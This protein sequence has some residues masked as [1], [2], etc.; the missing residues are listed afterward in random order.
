M[1]Y[2]LIAGEASGDLHASCLMCELRRRDARAEFRCIGGDLMRE[3]GGTLLRHYSR[4]AYMGVVPVLMHLPTI[5]RAMK[6]CLGD[7]L[8]WH[9]D[10]LILVDY[11]GFN[12]EIAQRVKEKSADI[13]VFYYIAPKLWAWKEYRIKY[14]RRYVDS[15]FSILPF[16]V[17]FFEEKHHCP[18]NYVGNPTLDEVSAYL[19]ANPT[20]PE[21]FRHGNGLDGSPVIAL[22]AGSR[23]QEIAD[24]LPRM[25][26]A[27]L[28]LAG[29]YQLVVAGAPGIERDFYRRYTKGSTVHVLYGQTYQILQ[30]SQAALVTSGTA[31]LE[32]ALFGVP[33]VVCYYMKAGWL[34]NLGRRV[35]IKAPFISLVNLIAGCEVVPELVAARMTVSR[36][37]Q[38]LLSILPGGSSRGLMLEG[39][40]LM[41]ARLGAPGAPARAAKAMLH[42]IARRGKEL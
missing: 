10:A 35:I 29:D 36:V 5:L 32:T 2:Y 22:L 3:Q 18:V 6:E 19:A 31:T 39:Y 7:I 20:D 26:R 21:A 40:A 4:L 8:D 23:R 41:S 16:E 12:L 34:A 17:P 25:L 37:R 14:I 1:R 42:L 13:P 38:H 33:Q 30:H 28:P 15:L 27:A 9:P 11:P 24:N